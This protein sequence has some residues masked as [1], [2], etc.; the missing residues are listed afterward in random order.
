MSRDLR[1]RS[2][3]ILFYIVLAMSLLVTHVSVNFLRNLSFQPAQTDFYQ[4]VTAALGLGT[5]LFTSDAIGYLFSSIHI[6]MWNI[7]RGRFH[8]GR[9]GYSAEWQRLEY[10]LKAHIIKEFSLALRSSADQDRHRKIQKRWESYS[11]DVFLSYFWQQAPQGIV[12]W[13][14]RRHTAFF[15]GMSTVIAIGLGLS[16]SAIVISAFRMGW[17]NANWYITAISAI[18]AFMLYMN[19]QYARKEA[20]EIMDLW[21]SGKLNPQLQ[22]ILSS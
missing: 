5:I 15:T 9:G 3:G 1:I 16:I 17:T 7:V 4:L 19:A 21:L 20:F 6:F 18:V 22:K 11:S 8:Q 12:D 10:D 2:A 13:T 14:S